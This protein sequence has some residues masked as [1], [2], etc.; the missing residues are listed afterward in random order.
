MVLPLAISCRMAW[1]FIGRLLSGEAPENAISGVPGGFVVQYA[2]KPE[3]L[4]QCAE[5]IGVGSIHMRFLLLPMNM[6]L[7]PANMRKNENSET[8]NGR[9]QAKVA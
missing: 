7:R 3:L 6:R 5:Q 4:Q 1:M 2:L 9:F 8:G